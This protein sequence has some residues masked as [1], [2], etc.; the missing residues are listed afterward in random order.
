MLK[1]DYYISKNN[2]AKWNFFRTLDY[3]QLFT[4]KSLWDLH[5]GYGTRL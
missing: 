3:S 5:K 1:E 2:L 4:I